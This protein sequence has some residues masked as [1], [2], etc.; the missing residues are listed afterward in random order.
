[1]NKPVL[2]AALS[3]LCSVLPLPAFASPNLIANGGFEQSSFSG[4]YATYGAGSTALSGWIIGGDSIDLI[5][6]YWQPASGSYSLDL[7]GYYDGTISQSIATTQGQRYHVTFDMAGNPDD[8]DKVKVMQVGLA[9][10]PLYTFDTS[11]RTQSNMGWTT[12]GFDFVATGSHSTLFFSSLQDS[13]YGVA[14][15]NVSVTA[16][17][18]P[19]SY[20]MIL[21]G[22]GLLGVITRRRSQP[23]K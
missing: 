8:D 13:A 1:M 12:K 22:L 21:S 16:V 10:Q 17:P 6:H 18:E 4:N 7:S 14:L 5:N 11:G 23:T 15:D 3:T 19:E 9:G 20:A 2:F